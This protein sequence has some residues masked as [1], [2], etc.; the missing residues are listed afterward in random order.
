MIRVL[1]SH[2]ISAVAALYSSYALCISLQGRL[3]QIMVRLSQPNSRIP[4]SL[5]MPD[6]LISCHNPEQLRRILGFRCRKF[7]KLNSDREAS[8]SAS[9]DRTNEHSMITSRYLNQITGTIDWLVRNEKIR[10][11][12]SHLSRADAVSRRSYAN[13][14]CLQGRIWQIEIR[15]S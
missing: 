13:P 8:E 10:V 15:M 12:Q 4:L 14:S 7:N 11:L 2:L 3:R 6:Q 1:L 5:Y 9:E